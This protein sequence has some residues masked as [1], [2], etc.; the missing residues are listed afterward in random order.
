M[1]DYPEEKI[2]ETWDRAET[3]IRNK[4]A[5]LEEEAQEAEDRAQCCRKQVSTIR[6]AVR[7]GRWWKLLGLV[8]KSDLELMCEV[9]PTDRESILQDKED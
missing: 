9:E 2:Q 7:E 1:D 3:A 4:I 6:A 8:N 5:A